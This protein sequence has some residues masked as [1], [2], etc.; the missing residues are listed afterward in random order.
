MSEPQNPA[1][2]GVASVLKSLRTRAGLREDRLSDTELSLDALTGLDSV[3]ELIA[4]GEPTERAIVRAVRTAAGTLDPTL[5]IVVDASL[6]LELSAGQIDDADLYARDLGLRRIA[7]LRHWDRLHQLRSVQPGKRPSA[8]ALRLEVEAD[9]LSALAD[10]L[11]APGGSAGHPGPGAGRA[12]DAE[13]GGKQAADGPQLPSPG[14][15]EL[16]TFGTELHNTLLEREL[17]APEVASRMAVSVS[18]VNGWLDGS[19]LPSEA[20]TT[21]LDEVLTARG[22]IM[23]LASELRAQPGASRGVPSEGETALVRSAGEPS[24]TLGQVFRKVAAALRGSLARAD[25]GTPLGWPQDL[26]QLSDRPP[27]AVSTAYGLR[28]MLLL[29]GDLAPDLVPVVENLRRMSKK[30]G[31]IPRDPADPEDSHPPLP[32]S[33]ES[34][35]LVTE[36]LHRVDGTETFDAQVAAMRDGLTEFEESRPFI[37]TIMLEA[38]LRLRGADELTKLLAE[39]L[40]KA[41]RP[42]GTA[43][44]WPE[45]AEPLLIDPA[46][47]LAHSARAVRA[48]ARLR[49]ESPDEQLRDDGQ[50]RDAVDQGVSWLLDQRQF[51]IAIDVVDRLVSGRIVMGYTR[52]FTAAWV[53]KALISA[54]IPATHPTVSN[55][56]GEVWDSYAG[57]TAA[58]W[59]WQNGDL[60]VWLTCDAVEAL[61][62]ASQAVPA[63]PGR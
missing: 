59:K 26:R 3:K 60:P 35:A 19:D 39:N 46:P 34:I 55:A 52:H 7:L 13:E 49:Q 9:A 62:L 5:S 14:S 28:T 23:Q 43:L 27:T 2:G 21:R 50:L 45:K 15:A 11:T 22:A 37:L 54:G 56:V 12:A 31:I 6:G 32:S 38:G 58:L 42:Y 1:A 18:V 57:D 61:L 53:V 8:R 47:S 63:G 33:P 20:D 51:P 24:G 16:Q 25:D 40:L 30:A 41:R 29:E 4:A 44:L 17:T 36:T 10:A 48:L